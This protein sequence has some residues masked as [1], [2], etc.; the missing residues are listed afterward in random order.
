M[1][2]QNQFT[3][4][5]PVVVFN[6]CMPNLNESE[7]AAVYMARKSAV[8]FTDWTDGEEWSARISNNGVPPAG[9]SF[10]GKDLIRYFSVIGDMPPWTEVVK[11]ISGSRRQI[12]RKVRTINATIDETTSENYEFL[13]VLELLSGITIRLW[14]L[15]KG[16]ILYGGNTGILLNVQLKPVLTRGN[17]ELEVF[18]MVATW[19]A[20]QSPERIFTESFGNVLTPS[21]PGDGGGGEPV[22]PGEIYRVTYRATGGE[23]GFTNSGLV[24]CTIIAMTRG[25]AEVED[26]KI[27]GSAPGYNQVLHDYE[28]GS[29]TF[30]SEQ[31]LVPNEFIRVVCKANA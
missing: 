14:F 17:G 28:T 2:N 5:L 7:I 1:S 24:N 9:S 8:P 21:I 12:T 22:T 20:A 3:E 11:E 4:T 16:G 10:S 26:I 18:Q 13:R 23:F 27:D 30:N 19:T 31:P 29:A 25:G 15:T 6:S